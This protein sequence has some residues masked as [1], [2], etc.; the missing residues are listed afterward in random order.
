MAAFPSINLEL[1]YTAIRRFDTTTTRGAM[2]QHHSY[3]YSADA[4]L[5]WVLSWSAM[6]DADLATLRQFWSDQKGGLTAFDF[7]DPDTGVTT[8]CIF[9]DDALSVQPQG[10]DENRL[11]IRIEQA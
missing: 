1:P 10:P 3:Y 7:T 9:A 8:S 6:S 5:S 2:G 11:T 4:R